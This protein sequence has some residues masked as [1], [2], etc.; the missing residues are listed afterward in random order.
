VSDCKC[1]HGAQ[2]PARNPEP[3]PY[4]TCLATQPAAERYWNEPNALYGI[5]LQHDKEIER[6]GLLGYQDEI[7]WYRED[8]D[9]LRRRFYEIFDLEEAA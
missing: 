9:R 2:C 8:Q 7:D 4:C 6:L 5:I 1:C 3:C